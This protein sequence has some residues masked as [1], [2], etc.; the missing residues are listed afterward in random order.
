MNLKYWRTSTAVARE[1]FLLAFLLAVALFSAYK[2]LDYFDLFQ[3]INPASAC[4][5]YDYGCGCSKPTPTPT[6]I[7]Q[8]SPTP[9]PTVS[10]TPTPTGILTPTPTTEPSVTPTPTSS[11]TPTP[12]SPPSSGNGGGGGGGVGGGQPYSCPAPTP[13]TPRLISLNRPAGDKVNLTWSAVSDVTHYALAYG[14]INQGYTF[15]VA[16]TGNVTTFQ[17][18]GLDPAQNY[19]FAVQAVNDCAPSAFSNQLCTGKAISTGQVLGASTLAAT[20]SLHEEL[21]NLCFII[22]AV[23]L[24]F[25]LKTSSSSSVWLS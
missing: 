11:P 23:C 20:G 25:G 14:L 13:E 10:P 24:A 22:G 5:D 16:N 9:T 17:V 19:C 1:F 7:C 12:T 15:G 18:G 21:F 2:I 8:P 4:Y 3:K 6:P